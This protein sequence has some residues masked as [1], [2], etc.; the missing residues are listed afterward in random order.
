MGHLPQSSVAYD[1]FHYQTARSPQSAIQSTRRTR[2]PPCQVCPPLPTPLPSQTWARI[3]P[4]AL[5]KGS[6]CSRRG[7]RLPVGPFRGPPDAAEQ[8]SPTSRPP[9]VCQHFGVG[10]HGQTRAPPCHCPALPS[11]FSWQTWQSWHTWNKGP[12]RPSHGRT[13]VTVLPCSSCVPNRSCV[14][15]CW[16]WQARADTGTALPLPGSAKPFFLADMGKRRASP[17]PCAVRCMP[18]ASPA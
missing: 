4:T 12:P 16:G 10:T 6:S 14:P 1:A 9:H 3:H 13:A 8:P 11:P 15:T 17:R 2:A 18:G 7:P 5:R